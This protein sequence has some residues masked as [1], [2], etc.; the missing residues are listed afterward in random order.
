VP[1]LWLRGAARSV[2][3]MRPDAVLDPRDPEVVFVDV[4]PR[5]NWGKVMIKE[6][7]DTGLLKVDELSRCLLFEGDQE[8]WRIPAAS[9]ISAE[10][11][12]YRPASH[13]EGQA[14]GEMFFVTVIRA[15]VGGDVWEAPV[16][17]CHVEFRAKNNRLRETNAQALR[18]RIR[19]IMPSRLGAARPAE[20][21]VRT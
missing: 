15:N 2:I 20:P 7:S 16:S 12:S 9:L 21:G 13:V 5:A 11:E 4:I 8:R 6:F 18:D 14:G 3:E 10:V 17:K 1:M 19:S